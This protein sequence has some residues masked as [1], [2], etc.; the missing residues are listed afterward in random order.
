METRFQHILL[1]VIVSLLG[2]SIARAQSPE[3]NAKVNPEFLEI[4]VSV[5]TLAIEGFPTTFSQ[6]LNFT[7]RATE[8]FFLEFNYVLAKGVEESTFADERDEVPNSLANDNDFQHLNLLLG[9]NFFQGEFFSAD[10][11]AN[12]S[13]LYGVVGVGETEF[14]EEKRFTT[15]LGMGYQIAFNRKYIVHFDLRDYIYRSSLGNENDYVNNI[16]YSV[17]LSYLF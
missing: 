1:I 2:S 12:L 6:S 16:D 15:V 7:F 10:N 3:V 13:S 14:A 17:G 9:Y 8:D 5:G 4:G 11:T